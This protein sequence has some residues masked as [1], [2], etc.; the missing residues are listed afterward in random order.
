MLQAL[1]YIIAIGLVLA[2]LWWVFDY[3]G[4]PQPFNKWGKIIA[5]IIGVILLIGILFNIAGV[6]TGFPR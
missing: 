5:M 3:A 4:V 1:I 6:S 2:F